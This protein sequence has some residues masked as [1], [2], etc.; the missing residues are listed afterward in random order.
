M[1]TANIKLKQLNL[2]E[3]FDFNKTHDMQQHEQVILKMISA[4]SIGQSHKS[5]THIPE[6]HWYMPHIKTF[7][8]YLSTLWIRHLHPS[9]SHTWPIPS[10]DL[11]SYDDES[12]LYITLWVTSKINQHIQPT[13][14]NWVSY[15][16][17]TKHKKL[18]TTRTG[19]KIPEWRLTCCWILFIS[20]KQIQEMHEIEMPNYL[21]AQNLLYNLY[22][23]CSHERNCWRNGITVW[24]QIKTGSKTWHHSN[25]WFFSQD[26]NHECGLT[27]TKLE[28]EPKTGTKNWNQKLEPLQ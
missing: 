28:L 11:Q 23:C 18:Q 7:L 15:S 21:T 3:E 16:L 25:D 22:Y 13:G 24:E 5:L 9:E 27:V 8:I 2:F 12:S 20:L 26:W 1:P 19:D 4:L 14:C 10:W 17:F 6:N